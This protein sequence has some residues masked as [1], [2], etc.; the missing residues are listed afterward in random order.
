MP[1]GYSNLIKNQ[2]DN[3]TARNEKKHKKT[4]NRIVYKT[5]HKKLDWA[6]WSPLKTG[7]IPCAP[8]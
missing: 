6:T 7:V 2:T 3:A 5:H 1:K 8:E 4:N